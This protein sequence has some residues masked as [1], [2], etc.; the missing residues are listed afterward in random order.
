MQLFL[1]H[2]SVYN[3]ITLQQ[4]LPVQYYYK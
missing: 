4:V 1:A 2:A 3:A